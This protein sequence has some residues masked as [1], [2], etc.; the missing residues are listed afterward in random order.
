MLKEKSIIHLFEEVLILQG[1][2][3][4]E[5]IKGAIVEYVDNGECGIQPTIC[6]SLPS[7]K[8]EYIITITNSHKFLV[9]KE[10]TNFVNKSV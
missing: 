10:I 5:K 7:Q 3:S 2:V 1:Q 6:V 4:L 8:E 9:S